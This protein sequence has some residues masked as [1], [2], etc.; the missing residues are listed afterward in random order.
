MSKIIFANDQKVV[1][2]LK[3]KVPQFH[4]AEVQIGYEGAREAITDKV[5]L[6]DYMPTNMLP[7]ASEV[8]IAQCRIK[9]A[10]RDKFDAD[11][12]A[13]QMS[14]VEVF[15]VKKCDYKTSKASW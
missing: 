13:E 14:Y 6:T 9:G 1:D 12:L 15:K 7:L 4:D 2:A 3:I 11:E 5:V 8:A 10:T